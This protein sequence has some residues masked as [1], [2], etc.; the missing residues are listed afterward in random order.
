MRSPGAAFDLRAA[1]SLEL[2]A[3]I[4]ELD[5][6]AGKPK[7]VHR[8]RVRIKRARAL[9]HIGRTCA[10]GLS[11][12]FNDS[13]RTVMH[14][15]ARS[16]DLAALAETA[17]L[18]AKKASK[19]QAAALKTTADALDQQRAA[20]PP[21]DLENAR[22]GLNDLLALAQV[23]PEA[24]PRQ[25]K[26]GAKRIARRARTAC[27]RGRNAEQPV[28]RHEWRKREKD[29][30]HA[31]LLLDDHWPGKKR[32]KLGQRLGDT[33]GHERD[34]LLLT[35]RLETNPALAGKKK[36]AKRA[37]RVMRKRSDKFA[38]RADRIGADLHAGGA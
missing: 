32:C 1:L 14:A 4:D 37:I 10:P 35:E 25:V 26:R 11:Q 33:L 29:R 3:A 38:R 17:R 2:R 24:S 21:I 9:A 7:G 23:W 12:V 6:S 30:F 28:R 15:L 31:A 27:R 8:C 5:A 13:A 36:A 19:K 18:G 34:A 22:S 16:R 20:L